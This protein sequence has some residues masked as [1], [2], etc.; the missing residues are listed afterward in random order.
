MNSPDHIADPAAIAHAVAAI[1]GGELIVIP[2][3]TVY[4]I[5]S[6][7]FSTVA[8]ARLLAAKGRDENKPPPVLIH[9]LGQLDE[10]AEFTS[11]SLR[12]RVFSLGSQFWPGPLT[13]VVPTSLDFGWN[14][15][16]WGNTV[17]VRIPANQTAL[18][19]LRG[20]GPLAV[21]SANLTD[22]PA[23]DT[24]A[25]ARIYFGDLVSVY[26]DDGPSEIKVASTI[27]DCTGGQLR[28][29]REG[30]LLLDELAEYE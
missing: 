11:D 14:Q 15:T 2:T 16:A 1:R 8:V 13:L 30:A 29:L 21:T 5:A 18:E 24:A 7:P 17:A 26:F 27:V 3:D 22:Q 6:D 20:T 4:G 28:V 12:N 9:D 19:V 10:I 25:Q 23:A